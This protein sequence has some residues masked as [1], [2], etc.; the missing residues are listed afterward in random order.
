MANNAIYILLFEWPFYIWF[1]PNTSMFTKSLWNLQNLL[2][3]GEEIS[4]TLLNILK[5]IDEK[6]VGALLYQ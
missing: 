2:K 5:N 4:E 3:M 6:R 1:S